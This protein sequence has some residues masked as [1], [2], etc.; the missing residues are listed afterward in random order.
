VGVSGIISF[1]YPALVLFEK[2]ICIYWIE[3]CYMQLIT[4]DITSYRATV[5]NGNSI[6]V[7]VTDEPLKMIRTTIF[8]AIFR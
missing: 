7:D 1:F 6:N 3:F 2:S 8:S 4:K 5:R